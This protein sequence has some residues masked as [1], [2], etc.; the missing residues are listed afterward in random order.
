MGES[1]LVCI[2]KQG[3]SDK[4][5]GS[6]VGKEGGGGPLKQQWFDMH[7]LPKGQEKHDEKNTACCVISL[8]T[9]PMIIFFLA[10]N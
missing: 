9:S 6:E 4:W 5:W 7:P 2:L 1:G 10:F 8:C 3:D